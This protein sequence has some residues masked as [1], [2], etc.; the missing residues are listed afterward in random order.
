MSMRFIFIDPLGQQ[1]H[2]YSLSEL[3]RTLEGHCATEEELE[4]AIQLQPGQ[5]FTAKDGDKP[6]FGVR[7]TK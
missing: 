5:Q 1:H 2:N 6:V 7:R 3:F 4:K